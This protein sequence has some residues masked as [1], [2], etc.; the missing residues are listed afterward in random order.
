MSN[1]VVDAAI[2]AGI[3]AL[4]Q[5]TAFPTPPLLWGADV[6]CDT[7][8]DPTT[9]LDPGSVDVLSQAI[10]R[11]LDTPRGKLA[12]DPAYGWDLKAELH[13]GLT[14]ADVDGI[15]RRVRS[16]LLKDDRLRVVQVTVQ[17]TAVAQRIRVVIVAQPVDPRTGTF[18]AIM[19][20]TPASLVLEEITRL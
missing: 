13:A 5:E 15:A 17:T 11:R 1:A 3:A 12:D 9:V 7:D 18:R 2:A 19:V 8:L 10:H 20:A 16:E 4:V 6:S 14:T